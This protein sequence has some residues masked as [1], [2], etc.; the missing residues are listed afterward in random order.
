MKKVLGFLLACL[1]IPASAWAVETHFIWFAAEGQ[2]DGYRLYSGDAAGGP[3]TMMLAEVNGTEAIVNMPED[4]ES[5][6][7]CRA[8]NRYG[9]SVDSN[10]V[11]WNCEVPGPPSELDW[12]V[13]LFD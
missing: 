2:V 9:E 6:L 12:L 7:V 3:Y 5:Y 13:I 11:Y 4:V 10:E 1:L 8:F